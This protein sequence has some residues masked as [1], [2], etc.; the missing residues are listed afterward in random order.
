[1][2]LVGFFNHVIVG[3]DVAPDSLTQS[4]GV[5]EVLVLDVEP[6]SAAQSVGIR[7]TVRDAYGR[8]ELGDVLVRSRW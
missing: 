3:D 7:P 1:M 2:Q 5:R 4:L 8:I 6:G